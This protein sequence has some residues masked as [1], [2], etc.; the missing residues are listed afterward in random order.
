MNILKSFLY[1]FS[2]IK[3]CIVTQRNFRFHIV[4][5]VSVLLTSLFYG[6]SEAQLLWLNLAIFSVL[7]CEMINTAIESVVDMHGEE[8]N[9]NAAIAKDVAAGAVMLSAAFAVVVAVRLF[10]NTEKILYVISFFSA[11]PYMWLLLVLYIAAAVY[12]VKGVPFKEKNN[13]KI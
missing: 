6:F 5:A 3:H 11:R 12:F 7:V 13:G 4:A 9:V 1:A 8:Y 10:W 2:G